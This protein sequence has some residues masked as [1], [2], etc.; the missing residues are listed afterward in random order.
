MAT[1]AKAGKEA[2]V[3][4]ERGRNRG[5]E[6][7]RQI[8]RV[9]PHIIRFPNIRSTSLHYHH[10]HLFTCILIICRLCSAQ[11]SAH[12]QWPLPV[13]LPA[14]HTSAT[15]HNNDDLDQ[16][17]HKLPTSSGESVCS[18]HRWSRFFKVPSVQQCFRS[19]AS[20][21]SPSV[22]VHLDGLSLDDVTAL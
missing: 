17:K 16:Q 5:K 7:R 20:P 12:Q 4:A 14:H 21:P 19:T 10:H 9:L 11:Q 15:D 13:P 6:S 3:K 18:N 8:S 1:K 22:F 2:N